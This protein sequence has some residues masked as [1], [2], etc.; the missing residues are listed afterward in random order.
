MLQVKAATMQAVEFI[1]VARLGID[2]D[3]PVI[4]DTCEDFAPFTE[5]RFV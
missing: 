1:D 5:I 3:I 4:Y 2:G